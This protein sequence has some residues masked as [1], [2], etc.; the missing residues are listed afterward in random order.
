MLKLS[1]FPVLLRAIQPLLLAL[2][3]FTASACTFLSPIRYIPLK[4]ALILTPEAEALKKIVADRSGKVRTFKGLFKAKIDHAKEIYNFQYVVLLERPD[5]LRIEMLPSNF[6]PALGVLIVNGS[7]VTFIDNEG[8]VSDNL[9]EGLKIKELLGVEINAKTLVSLLLGEWPGT[10]EDIQFYRAKNE[11]LVTAIDSQAGLNGIF[12]KEGT[13]LEI[14]VRSKGNRSSKVYCKYNSFT[15]TAAGTLPQQ[16][17]FV[18]VEDN[19][20]AKISISRAQIGML[21]PEE[22]FE[23]SF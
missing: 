1:K 13:L 15:V 7:R 23:V 11:E 19:S 8:I 16:F 6:G 20:K 4:G 2:I 18:A 3:L 9:D 21:I 22:A 17:D 12:D 5:R 14:E 10:T